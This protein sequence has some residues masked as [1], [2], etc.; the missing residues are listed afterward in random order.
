[1]NIQSLPATF[2]ATVTDLQLAD[3]GDDEFA[4]LYEAWLEYA[5]L[6]FPGQFL[7]KVEQV[8]FAKRFGELEFDYAPISNLN[9][10]GEV[11]GD[12]DVMQILKGNMEWHCD[13]TYMPV[14]AKGAVFSAHTVPAEGGETGWADMRAAYHALA[15][16]KQTLLRG[17]KAYH[18][19]H[20]SQGKLGHKHSEQGEYSG[21]GFHN[22]DTPLRSL[23]KE[24]PETGVASLLVGRHAFGIPGMSESE[25]DAL[26]DEINV[27]ACQGDRVYYHR[28]QAGD[29]VVWD[30]RCLMHRACPWNLSEPRVMFHSRIKGD[31]VSDRCDA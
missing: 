21:Y 4:K 19:L 26:I 10:A 27:G 8:S 6:I 1:M 13:S 7:T 25:S 15:P 17:L 16:E 23:V 30:N 28:W 20:Y 14:M 5:L 9:K 11:R 29:V 3:L 22:D 24:H 31:P 12:D 18:S 2:G